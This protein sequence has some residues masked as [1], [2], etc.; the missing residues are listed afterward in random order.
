MITKSQKRKLEII[1]NKARG[2]E[3]VLGRRGKYISIQKK[4]GLPC[5]HRPARD[6][7]PNLSRAAS[8]YQKKGLKRGKTE[9]LPRQRATLRV[10]L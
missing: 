6:G 9:I 10:G 2:D 8:L 5:G 1:L 3:A 7:Y 4:I